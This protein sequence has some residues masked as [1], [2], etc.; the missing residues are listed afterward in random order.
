MD[1]LHWLGISPHPQK[2]KNNERED[3]IKELQ[4]ENIRLKMENEEYRKQLGRCQQKA[5]LLIYSIKNDNRVN[6]VSLKFNC[7]HT[8]TVLKYLPHQDCI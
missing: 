4:Q 6:T 2:R 8:V 7:T 3:H 1:V 5:G